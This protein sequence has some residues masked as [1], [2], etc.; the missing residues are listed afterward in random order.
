M[1]ALGEVPNVP[2]SILMAVLSRLDDDDKE[3][4]VAAVECLRAQSALPESILKTVAA[5]L[6]D[7]QVR[8]RRAAIIILVDQQAPSEGVIAA[9]IKRAGDGNS[10]IRIDVVEI[11]KRRLSLPQVM[12]VVAT[13]MGD[14]DA[15]VR[16]EATLTFIGFEEL[17]DDVLTALVKR[18][19]D[20][21]QSVR[22]AAIMA[23]CPRSD[24]SSDVLETVIASTQ[25]TPKPGLMAVIYL[26]QHY[27]KLPQVAE[28]ITA[29]L[30]GD[31]GETRLQV[32]AIERLREQRDLPRSI[33]DALARKLKSQ[34]PEVRWNAAIALV[35]QMELP[36]D[37]LK[38]VASLLHDPV[39][40]VRAVVTMR[41]S[42]SHLLTGEMIETLVA[43]TS[44]PEL[45]EYRVAFSGLGRQPTLP[46]SVVEAMAAKLDHRDFQVAFAAFC[47]LG[48]RPDLTQEILGRH[49]KTLY[50][51][52]LG[53][54][55]DEWMTLLWG[56]ELVL[57]QPTGSIRISLGDQRSRIEAA[58]REVQEGQGVPRQVPGLPGSF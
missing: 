47:A 35:A 22:S 38:S 44:L 36:K 57:D 16:Q 3:A 39:F 2:E 8:V 43:R 50:H 25:D 21:S 49:M 19:R 53:K 32:E 27:L 52:W 11:L 1:E 17:R 45:E 5:R 34:D 28:F 30:D 48:E 9:V 7:P 55:F 20:E 58:I 42:Q 41:L 37:I 13:M 18:L 46:R 4:R 29:Q 15:T 23:L 14:Q 6:E 26:H 10:R 31:G 51:F 24:L 40:S 33:V 54:S 12:D 56:D